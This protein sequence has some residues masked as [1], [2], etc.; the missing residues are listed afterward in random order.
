MAMGK[1]RW[2]CPHQEAGFPGSGGVVGGGAPAGRTEKVSEEAGVI[3]RVGGRIPATGCSRA[4][5]G[6]TSEGQW[7]L[8]LGPSWVC[9]WGSGSKCF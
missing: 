1:D 2:S 6:E 5:V 9:L 8:D 7:K 4:G 3:G